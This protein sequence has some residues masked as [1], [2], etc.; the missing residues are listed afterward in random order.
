MVG[1]ER[2]GFAEARDSVCT[3]CGC[4]ARLALTQYLTYYLREY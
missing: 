4:F 2:K 1:G 3:K